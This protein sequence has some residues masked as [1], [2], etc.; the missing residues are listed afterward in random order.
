[1]HQLK[2]K[3]KNVNKEKIKCWLLEKTN[4]TII[5]RQYDSLH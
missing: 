5:C 2:I 3:M 1:M 4:K